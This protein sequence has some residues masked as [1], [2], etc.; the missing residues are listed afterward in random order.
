M[1]EVGARWAYLF[2]TD[3]PQSTSAARARLIRAGAEDPATGSAAGPLGAY[4]V[5]YGV[6]RPGALDIEQGI[7]MGRPS[8]IS[9]NVPQEA[10]EIGPVQ[11]AGSVRIWGRGTL[12]EPAA[13]SS[14]LEP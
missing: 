3:T 1:S 13:A 2:S 12:Q 9:V 5:Y 14:M 10:G 4:L 8:R 11:V 7:E 6:H